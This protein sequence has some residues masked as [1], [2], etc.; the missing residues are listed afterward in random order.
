MFLQSLFL[1]LFL[2]LLTLGGTYNGM[3]MPQVRLLTMGVLALTV[4]VWLAWRTLKRWR[5]A[6]TPLDGVIAV[7]AV[8][9]LAS[10]LLNLDTWRRSAI[11]I[12]EIGLYVGLWYLL[13]DVL[14]NRGMR[15]NRLPLLLL[16]PGALVIAIGYMQVYNGL[17][18]DGAALP[19]PVSLYGNANLLAAALLVM[20]PI[21]IAVYQ[22]A[23]GMVRTLTG[24]LIALALPLFL[25]TFSRAA[26]LGLMAAALVLAY[27]YRA[28]LR[29]RWNAI[30]PALR[31]MIAALLIGSIGIGGAWFALTFSQGG[32]GLELRTF[33]YDSALRLF[34]EAPAFGHGMFTFGQGLARLNSVPPTEPHAHAHNLI[35]QVGAEFGVAGLIVLAFGAWMI[36]RA[37]RRTPLKGVSW[38]AAAALIGAGVHHLF[39]FPSLTPAIVIALL[40]VL[41][42]A[43]QPKAQPFRRISGVPVIAVL[44]GVLLFVG[45]YDARNYQAYNDALAYGVSSGDYRG[46]AERL[47]PVIAADPFMPIYLQQQGFL[48]GLAAER[49]DVDA[50]RSAAAALERLI[51]LEP[52]LIQGWA[53]AAA[54]YDVQGE[55]ALAF[56][57]IQ[58]ARRR[59]PDDPLLL[60][61]YARMGDAAGAEVSAVY[62]EALAV[63][64]SL[65]LLP[66]WNDS[67]QRRAAAASAPPLTGW[68]AFINAALAGTLEQARTL[69]APEWSEQQIAFAEFWL[70][71]QA[72]DL[73]AA[74]NLLPRLDALANNWVTS[75]YSQI[76]R[77]YF[78][79]AIGDQAAAQSA[80]QRVSDLLQNSLN[81]PD[82]GYGPNIGY[83]QFLVPVITQQFLDGVD[84]RLD[85]ILERL[86]AES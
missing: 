78:A 3:V 60:Y 65:V 10:T 39:D 50:G 13:N 56:D 40:V 7:G 53:N 6:A 45:V 68:A 77:L 52:N 84:Y 48:Y 63:N 54:V 82:W 46:A 21:G 73:A 41:V 80:R 62:A 34:A 25:L 14:A 20:I 71:L 74:Q 4:I 69:I 19:R 72:G 42:I 5:W 9:L 49:G 67:P 55:H 38:G 58:E 33:I 16:L 15:A 18:V 51:A 66:D 23:R 57:A 1:F 30:R 35:L 47:T 61:A 31:A 64:P 12:W 81:I 28:Q 26:Y 43:V 32:R 37:L 27:P 59:A 22:T 36:A 17:R 70:A 24:L 44:W 76:A 79:N 2:Y 29:T 75:G 86:L 8:V 85:P 83:T 11:G